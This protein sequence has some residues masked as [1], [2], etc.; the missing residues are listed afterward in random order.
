MLLLSEIYDILKYTYFFSTNPEETIMAKKTL[1]QA[2]NQ[3]NESYATSRLNSAE[4]VLFKDNL[5]NLITK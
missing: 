3:Y 4:F 2:L 1:S 5:K